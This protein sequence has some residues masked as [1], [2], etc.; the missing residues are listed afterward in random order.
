MVT[1]SGTAGGGLGR[2]EKGLGVRHVPVPWAGPGS[3]HHHR[4]P[5]ECGRRLRRIALSREIPVQKPTRRTV[6]AQSLD[7]T[8]PKPRTRDQLHAVVIAAGSSLGVM[9][10]FRLDMV[11]SVRS[12]DMMD[13]DRIPAAAQG[14]GR[15]RR[16]DASHGE[17]HPHRLGKGGVPRDTQP[18]SDNQAALRDIADC[19]GCTRLMQRFRNLFTRALTLE[20][21]YNFHFDGERRPL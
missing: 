18:A 21:P 3:S 1:R 19:G 2:A 9:P 5:R 13:C 20:M 17:L 12:G 8:D 16:D 10:P 11:R 4:A 7:A 15:H 14:P 6:R